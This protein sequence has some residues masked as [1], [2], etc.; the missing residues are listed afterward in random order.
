MIV[1]FSIVLG[2]F[3]GILFLVD[4]LSETRLSRLLK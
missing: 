3:Y 2:L 1:V 4:D